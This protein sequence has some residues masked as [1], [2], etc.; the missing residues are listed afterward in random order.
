MKNNFFLAIFII[1]FYSFTIEYGNYIPK[2]IDSGNYTRT[3]TSISTLLYNCT[4]DYILKVDKNF[5]NK[6]WLYY[7]IYFFKKD[8]NSYFTIWTFTCFPSYISS[9]ID[10]SLYNFSLYEI[11]NR[12]VV[13]IDKK[14]NNNHLFNPSN[15]HY[16]AA[17]KEE[18]KTYTGDIYDGSFY[19]KTFA[20]KEKQNKI[21]ITVSDSIINNFINCKKLEVDTTEDF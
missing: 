11:K 15:I 9:C 7:N 1:F 17:K 19:F 10:T 14:D 4:L 18:M 5:N 21:I 16:L 12:K 2:K 13:I 6:K 3:D 20:I 8:S